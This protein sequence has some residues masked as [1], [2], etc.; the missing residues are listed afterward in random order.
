[1]SQN[2]LNGKLGHSLGLKL[3]FKTTRKAPKAVWF[4]RLDDKYLKV[5]TVYLFVIL[6]V[7]DSKEER[8]FWTLI[9]DFFFTCWFKSFNDPVPTTIEKITDKAMSIIA[10]MLH[11]PFKFTF[12]NVC[13]GY[14]QKL[15]SQIS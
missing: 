10:R 3:S 13:D 12:Y 8:P 2:Q 6:E 1:M 4:S 5:E 11:L 15:P 9:N 14:T 7:K